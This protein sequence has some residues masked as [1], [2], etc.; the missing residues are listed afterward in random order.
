VYE[1]E[2]NYLGDFVSLGW[3]SFATFGGPSTG[4][5][6]TREGL[7]VVTPRWDLNSEAF[8][9]SYF[10]HEGRH[11]ADYKKYPN[12]EQPDL[13]YRAKLTELAFSDESTFDLLNKF[14]QHAAKVENAPHPLA[15]WHVI[16]DL[17]REFL[18][19]EWPESAEDWEKIPAFEIQAFAKKL[20]QEHNQALQAAGVK[21][22]KGIISP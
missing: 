16:N 1:F 9:I 20:L 11:F 14:T 22:T 5:W 4:G 15:N 21:T 2:V 7:F 6:A 10:M 8:R 19:G 18:N 13:E 3:A 12:L 17:S